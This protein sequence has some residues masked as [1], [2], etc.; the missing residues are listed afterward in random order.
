M[1]C[2][3]YAAHKDAAGERDVKAEVDQHVP[4][5]LADTDGPAAAETKSG[6]SKNT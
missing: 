1:P 2:L 3:I 4:K 6:K 5:F